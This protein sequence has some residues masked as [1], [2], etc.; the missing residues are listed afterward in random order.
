M[1]QRVALARTLME[2][3]P[4]VLMDEPFSALDAVTR[5]RLQDWRPSCWPGAPCCWSPTT[6]SRRSASA[7]RSGCWAAGRH[8]CR[9]RCSRPASRRATR[10]T[11]Q[12]LRMQAELLSELA[13]RPCC[14]RHRE[15]SPAARH[16]AGLLLAWELLVRLSGCRPSSCRA[17]SPS[18]KRWQRATT[19]CFRTRR[20]R[21]P[22]S[23]PASSW[24]ARSV[25]WLPCCLPPRASPAAGSCPSWS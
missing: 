15:S 20:P 5:H 18:S 14:R 4:V 2:D 21:Q 16:G 12:L 23:W 11:R 6:R 8:S 13:A 7:T 22:R 19:S 1:R 3:R 24:A 9:R 25:P 10:P 17:R